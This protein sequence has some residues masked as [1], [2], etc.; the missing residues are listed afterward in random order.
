MDKPQKILILAAFAGVALW[1]VPGLQVLMLPFIYLGTHIHELC[2]ALMA[3]AT[4]GQPESIRVFADGSGVTPVQGGSILLVAGA[5]YPGAA[6]VGSL[7][8]LSG[9]SERGARGAVAALAATLG[10]SLLLLVRGDWAGIFGAVFWIPALAL[11]AWRLKGDQIRFLA[12]FLGIEIGLN[13]FQSLATLLKITVSSSIPTDASI[14]AEHYWIPAP[15]WAGL[16]F[17]FSVVFTGLSLAVL[18]KKS[19]QPASR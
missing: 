3:L 18:L 10:L 4:G 13:A 16:F 9:R 5:G 6:V 7:L 14:L 8:V 19:Q 11:L 1:V 17:V 12:Q 2:H 15:I